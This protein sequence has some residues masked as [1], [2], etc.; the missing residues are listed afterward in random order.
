MYISVTRISHL[1]VSFLGYRLVSYPDCVPLPVCL[2]LLSNTR[3]ILDT[4]PN[5]SQHLGLT[6]MGAGYHLYTPI[7]TIS[8]DLNTLPSIFI[9]VGRSTCPK[10]L[11]SSIVMV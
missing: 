11:S 1:V 8:E 7:P 3:S 9:S 2:P 10:T 6:L 5:G 4:N